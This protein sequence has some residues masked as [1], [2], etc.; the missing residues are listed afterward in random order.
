MNKMK[1]FSALIAFGCMVAAA[2][3][4]AQYTV[5]IDPSDATQGSI[6]APVGPMPA[7]IASGSPL[8][9]SNAPGY[10]FSYW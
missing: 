1:A 6:T 5:Y 4:L 3:A 7:S 10:M 8:I 2:P 9:A